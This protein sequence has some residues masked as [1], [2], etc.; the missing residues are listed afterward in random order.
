MDHKDNLLGILKTLYQWKKPIILICLLAGIGSS[1]IVLLLPVYFQASTTFIVAS[2]DQA[3][4]EILFSQGNIEPE[5]F[6]NTNDIDRVLTIAESNE[7]IDFL[8]DS[9]Q[10]YQHYDINPDGSKAAYYVKQVLFDLYDIKK[11]KRDALQLTIEDTEP[12]LAARMARAAREKIAQITQRL[13]KQS[14][15]KTIAAFEK[16]IQTKETYLKIYGDSLAQLRDTFGIYNSDAQTESL[17]ERLNKSRS[18]LAFNKARAT[19][20]KAQNG[21][22]DSIRNIQSKVAGLEDEVAFLTKQLKRFNEGM[23]P[24]SIVERQYFETNVSLGYVQEKMK[25]YKTAFD[26][27]IS[28]LL[29]IEE[30]DV[31]II[32][33]RPKR[34][35]T[36]LAATMVAF[37]FSIIGVLL[38]DTYK[39][40]NWREI[41]SET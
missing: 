20:L 1:I 29:L 6:G 19:S 33:S 3:K 16:D 39:D 9:F 36:V 23:G 10:L 28:T 21:K 34:T 22:R 30:A 2:P 8:I 7:L 25:Q 37:L 24:I 17:T 40:I 14:Q 35:I 13:L 15:Q 32:K 27:P 31:P 5:L 11:T 41:F 12:E 26:S 18:Q 4:P 38:F